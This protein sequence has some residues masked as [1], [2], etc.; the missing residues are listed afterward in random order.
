MI[1]FT[2]KNREDINDVMHMFADECVMNL[3]IFLGNPRYL[4]KSSKS[5]WKRPCGF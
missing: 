5:V 4:W 3:K 2:K 1:P